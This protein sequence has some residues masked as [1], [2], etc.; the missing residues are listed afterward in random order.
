MLDFTTLWEEHVCYFTRAT[1]LRTFA[2]A[3]LDVISL[4]VYP[5]RLENLLVAVVRVG[6][7]RA[8][9]ESGDASPPDAGARHFTTAVTSCEVDLAMLQGFA[10]G[11]SVQRRRFA[12]VLDQYRRKGPV[13]VLGAGHLACA[14]IQY[15]RLQEYIAMVVDDNPRKQGLLMPGSRIPIRAAAAL[16]DDNVSLCLLSVNPEV[17]EKVIERNRAFL[18]RGGRFASIFMT[19]NRRLI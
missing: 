18:D 3:G 11:L 1:F 12:E 6:D 5:Y 19:S 7:P 9:L 8:G 15:L 17:E 13:A 10:E 2:N 4:A 14:F 16:K